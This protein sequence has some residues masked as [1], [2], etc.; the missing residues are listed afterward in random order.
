LVRTTPKLDPIGLAVEAYRRLWRARDHALLLGLPLLALGVA[1]NIVY[2][3]DLRALIESANDGSTITAEKLADLQF[4]LLSLSSIYVV[5]ATLLHAILFGN[6]SR[7]LLIGPGATRPLLGLALDARL[8]SVIWRFIQVILA[9]LLA[10]M[11]MSL[12]LGLVVEL[13]ARAGNI[14]FG[15]GLL[16]MM[17]LG[18]AILVLCLRL[19]VACVATAVDRPMRLVEA[20]RVTAGN[21]TAM[22]GAILAANLPAVAAGF[23]LSALLNAVASSIPMTATLLLSLVG[24]VTSLVSIAVVALAAE[25]LL[26]TPPKRG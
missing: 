26:A 3:D 16:A 24:L 15:I 1:W 12:P 20:W 19:L 14:G 23:V 13:A 25:R 18:L 2:A 11:L 8:V 9:G 21:A 4:A 6:L 22:L 5:P 7:L 10:M 17:G